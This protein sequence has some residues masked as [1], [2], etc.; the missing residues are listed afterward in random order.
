M[1]LS[2]FEP[3]LLNP[4]PLDLPLW[5]DNYQEFILKLTTNFGPHDPV[6][7]VEHQLDNLSM[8][9]GAHIN[10]YIVKFNHLATQV[11]GYGKGTL[12]HI[13]YNGLPDHIKDEITCIRKP[14]TLS[15]LWLR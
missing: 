8:K 2:W 13:F 6:R 4:S 14:P 9:D 11:C 15:V 5:V 12:H 3:D 7:D 10:K 1:A